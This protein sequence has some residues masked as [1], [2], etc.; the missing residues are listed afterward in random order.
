M[1]KSQKRLQARLNLIENKVEAVRKDL[2]ILSRNLLDYIKK[3]NPYALA[4]YATN[5][6]GTTT[7]YEKSI[8]SYIFQEVSEIIGL[9]IKFTYSLQQIHEEKQRVFDWFSEINAIT[10][11]LIETAK[12]GDCENVIKKH[13]LLFDKIGYDKSLFTL[14]STLKT[15]VKEYERAII[16]ESRENRSWLFH[17]LGFHPIVQKSSKKLFINGHFSQAIFEASKILIKHVEK[18]AKIQDVK[19][20][21]LM[22]TVFKIDYTRN[23]LKITHQPILKLNSLKTLEDIDEQYG[24]RFLFQGTVIGI[25]NPKAHTEVIQTD[26]SKTL[27]YL[28]LISLLAKRTDEAVHS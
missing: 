26:Q 22:A 19:A 27:E 23:P 9:N 24:F 6:F 21:D 2:L 10:E 18:K 11:D 15:Y 4:G 25:R 1:K 12:S 3:N 17:N 5:I 8:E 14:V 7:S 13:R 16:I 28:S 20:S